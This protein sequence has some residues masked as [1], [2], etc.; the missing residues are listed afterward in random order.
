M[1]Q[2]T[3]DDYTCRKLWA[4]GGVLWILKAHNDDLLPYQFTFPDD[5]IW[6]CDRY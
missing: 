2:S 4:L 5:V 1:W 3:R 6:V